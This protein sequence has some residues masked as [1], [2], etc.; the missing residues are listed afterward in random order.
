M[1]GQIAF[2][3]AQVAASLSPTVAESNICC[4]GGRVFD[5]D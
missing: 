5:V 1:L 3:R 2:I 4:A